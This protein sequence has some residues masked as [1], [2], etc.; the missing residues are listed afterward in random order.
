[1]NG[2]SLPHP[3]KKRGRPKE[4]NKSVIGLPRKRFKTSMPQKLVLKHIE[5]SPSWV[6]DNL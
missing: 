3:T 1:M 2:V 5:G 6:C 4:S